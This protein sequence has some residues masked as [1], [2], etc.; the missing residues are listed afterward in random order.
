MPN[1]FS[2][3][4]VSLNR[5]LYSNFDY[6]V[7]IDP[8]EN[9]VGR[10]VQIEFGRSKDIGIIVE[11][12]TNSTYDV[13]K[14]KKAILLDSNPLISKDILQ[15]LSFASTYYHYP[16]GQCLQVALPKLLRD[17]NPAQY[18]MIVALKLNENADI[19]TIKNEDQKKIIKLLEH[20]I[21]TRK[22]L[23]ER[24]FSVY[25]ENA[26]VK[27]KIIQKV[28][29]ND[30]VQPYAFKQNLIKHEGPT[31]NNEQQIAVN[32]INNHQGFGVFLLNGI[33]G[34]GKTE[35]YLNAI[36]YQL[37]QHKRVLVL[38]PEIALTPQTFTRFYDRFNV[39]IATMHSS[40][41]D[42]ERTD[43]FL[44]MHFDR[45]MILIGTR[46]ALF[47][48][49]KNLGLIIIDEEHDSS[50]KQ[51]DGLRYHARSL[52]IIRAKINNAKVVLG[53]ATPSIESLHNCQ[54]GKYKA[55]YLTQRAGNALTPDIELID[56]KQAPLTE[57]L[58]TGIGSYLEEQIGLETAKGN[59][60]LLFL[61]RRGYS[62]SLICH[63]CGYVFTCKQCDNPLT[64]HK[65]NNR[66][67]C[68]I[69]DSYEI[70]PHNCPKC[71]STNL[72]ETGF[73]TEQVESFLRHRY[74]D[75]GIVRI[76]RDNVKNKS[77]LEKMIHKIVDK[78][79]NILIGT[80]MLA[81]GHD[82]PDVTLVGILD[83]DS[84]LFSDDF[85]SHEQTAQL[86]VQVAGRSGRALKRGRV[87][88][89]SYN[90]D[91]PL[92]VN[93]ALNH[94]SYNDIALDL[95]NEREKMQLPPFSRLAFILTNCSKREYAF[96]YLSELYKYL[97][98]KYII[99]DLPIHISPPM[100]DKIEK[101]HNRY[102]FNILIK[103][104]NF[105]L[106]NSI[107]NDIQ[108]Y[109]STKMQLQG[110]CRFAIDVDPQ[111]LY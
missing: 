67:C 55:L 70:M 29:F 50:F 104:A 35:V 21:V 1:S 83:I 105:H 63:D 100:S 26:L 87:L 24:G 79:A 57:G 75:A 52:A 36:A 34:S 40:L 49:I 15:T 25:A 18:K 2:I 66:L 89:Q 12:K 61:N 19:S 11:L 54:I 31:L 6:I 71:N 111:N 51:T 96:I 95:I 7:D 9:L 74:P 69:C 62:R 3:V 86:L 30:F 65:Q 76:D 27:K 48:P 77:D 90:L 99:K 33:T 110:D 60:V 102:H 109:T 92:I 44:D 38:V 84:N 13:K 32:S 45:A 14:L 23:R 28:D 56:L 58:Q 91:H 20:N 16:L 107:L 82:F 37:Q 94:K 8:H 106:F 93:L 78:S 103:S 5:P 80:Q 10:R 47:T 46:S 59:Q 64:V 108:H 4:G 88:I 73:G 98:D 43:A 68:H 42:R 85:R 41:S 97:Y 101:K 53:S 72:I 22:E 39:P 81:K 17:G